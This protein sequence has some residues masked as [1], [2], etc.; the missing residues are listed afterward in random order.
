MA[1]SVQGLGLHQQSAGPAQQPHDPVEMPPS[2]SGGSNRRLVFDNPP[3]GYGP[4]DLRRDFNSSALQ[5]LL[6]HQPDNQFLPVPVVTVLKAKVLYS[7]ASVPYKALLELT[8]EA[9][10][11]LHKVK[12]R[13]N[14]T[15]EVCYVRLHKP[16]GVESEDF[17]TTSERN[18][19]QRLRVLVDAEVQAQ[20]YSAVLMHQLQD[21]QH[22]QLAGVRQQR[23]SESQHWSQLQ[24][25]LERMQSQ[26]EHLE[27][28]S[29]AQADADAAARLEKKAV[30]RALKTAEQRLAALVQDLTAMKSKA[31]ASMS[32]LESERTAI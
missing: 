26:N 12:V 14:S 16:Q 11:Q 32:Q 8:S 10:E 30:L 29:K 7:R 19:A 18:H 22:A 17:L 23:I 13:P 5:V 21:L 31:D 27:R 2:G 24:K 3:D 15:G 28:N 1:P 20:R 6:S 4:Q 25:Q 9:V